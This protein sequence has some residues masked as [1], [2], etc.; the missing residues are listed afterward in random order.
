MNQNCR[1]ASSS[2]QNAIWISGGSNDP[3]DLWGNMD[4]GTGDG[5]VW[6][7]KACVETEIRRVD[8]KIAEL[9]A[10]INSLHNTIAREEARERAEAEAARERARA[11]AE[12][13]KK[14][15]A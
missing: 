9:N 13:R 5:N 15:N 1:N 3:W 14:Q 10:S 2:I 4:G 11:E 7:S 12:A 8:A 6:N